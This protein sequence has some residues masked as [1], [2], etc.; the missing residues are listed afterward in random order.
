PG[1]PQLHLLLSTILIR[2]GGHGEEAE[3]SAA[4]AAAIAPTSVP[5]HLQY[6]L[7]LTGNGN[8]LKAVEQFEKVVQLEPGSYEAWSSLASLYRALQEDSKAD[9]CASRAADLEP[10]TRTVRLR[11]L[12]NLERSGKGPQATAELKRL[13]NNRD[14]SPEFLQE[15]AGEAMSL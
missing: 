12:K 14:Y 7:V 13:I 10:A 1:N 5:A 3:Q 2:M 8:N 11:T 9:Q 4:T 15:L 6:A